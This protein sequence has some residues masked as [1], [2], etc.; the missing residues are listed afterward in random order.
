MSEDEPAAVVSALF[1]IA[2]FLLEVGVRS[3]AEIVRHL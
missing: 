1:F 3:H 2:G